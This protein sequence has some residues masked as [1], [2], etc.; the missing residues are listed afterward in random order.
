MQNRAKSKIVR[1]GKFKFRR[2]TLLLILV[3]I[4]GET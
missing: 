4:L 1:E 2:E 3:P